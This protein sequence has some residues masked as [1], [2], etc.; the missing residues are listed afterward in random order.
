MIWPFKKKVIPVSDYAPKTDP[1]NPDACDLC[2]RVFFRSDGEATGYRW[3]TLTRVRGEEK[4]DIFSCEHCYQAQQ[5]REYLETGEMTSRLWM[6]AHLRLYDGIYTV[7]RNPVVPALPEK[8]CRKILA[9][10][11]RIE[12]QLAEY[13]RVALPMVREANR[14][15]RGGLSGQTKDVKVLV[16]ESA[17]RCLVTIQDRKRKDQGGKYGGAQLTLIFAVGDKEHQDAGIQSFAATADEAVGLLKAAQ[18]AQ[19]P[20]FLK[21][22]GEVQF[23]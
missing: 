15:A 22:D 1:N 18:E 3:W 7:P 20:R 11:G 9:D 17:A 23:F 5:V 19:T 12:Q 2:G 21:D 8:V 16:L 4:Q 14:K 10:V 13:N 6:D